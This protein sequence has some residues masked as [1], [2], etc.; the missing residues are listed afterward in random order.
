MSHSHS[1]II[2]SRI[3][4]GKLPY[5]VRDK[6]NNILE[7]LNG[8]FKFRV[9]QYHTDNIFDNFPLLYCPARL[10][11]CLEFNLFLI[12]RKT[13]AFSLKQNRYTENDKYVWSKGHLNARKG[14]ELDIETILQI[15][16][17]LRKFLDWMIEHNISYE[18][19]M[20]IPQSFDPH[21]IM[22]AETLLPVWRFQQHLTNLVKE[23]FMS[24]QLGNRI[25][26]NIKTY[27]LWSFRRGEIHA[28]PFSL[29]FK[30]ISV[31]RLDDTESLFS[32]P[33]SIKAHP[34]AVK[35]HISNLTIPKNAIQKDSKP[36][37][38]LLAYT[39]EELKLLMKTDIYAHRTY[40]LFIKCALLAGLRANEV[41]QINRD[42][43]IDPSSNR[44][45]FSLSLLRKFSKKTNLRISPTLMNL[46][47][48][49]AQDKVY[50]ER[51]RKHEQQFGIN[52]S[53]HPL[54]LFINKNGQR[55]KVSSVTNSIQKIRAELKE[56][57]MQ[58]LERTFHDLR[59][60]FA[61]YWTIAL[62]KKGYSP[63][64]IKAKLMLLLSHESFETTQRYIDFA[65]E[66]RIG[67]HGAMEEWVVD[68]YQEVLD[69]VNN[70]G[71][72]NDT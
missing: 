65:L 3:N 57:G 23:K 55:M 42:E 50:L 70:I 38:G 17:D 43:V 45:S 63:N 1:K 62:I 8:D 71:D 24:Y 21:S 19:I 31:R 10:M 51:Q 35:A 46:L 22:E 26:Q 66:G 72:H 67:H 25:L 30:A 54:P 37:K 61:T 47:W 68:I 5:F 53:D 12:D 40:G 13:G 9:L 59:A 15:A 34:G 33:G 18:E 7:E 58:R 48:N 49:Y 28:L 6:D 69:K 39:A 60:T 56:R 41:V 14:S 64:E 11:E 20:A 27:Y 52:N 32:M 36:D 29:K 4:I 44:V 2:K 16:K